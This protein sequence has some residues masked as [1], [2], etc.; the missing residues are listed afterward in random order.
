MMRRAFI[1]LGGL[2]AVTIGAAAC[3]LLV[4]TG[5]LSNPSST[6]GGGSSPPTGTSSGN[7]SVPDGGGTE[8]GTLDEGGPSVARSYAEMILTTPG[9]IGYWRFGD[10]PGSASAASAIAGGKAGK[11]NQGVTLGAPSA[12]KNDPT[13]R[14]FAFSDTSESSVVD[15]GSDVFAFEGKSPFSIELWHAPSS[16]QSFQVLIG[17]HNLDNPGAS[18]WLMSVEDPYGYAVYRED[19]VSGDSVETRLVPVAGEVHHLVATYDGTYLHLYVDGKEPSSARLC[20]RSLPSN[21]N[22]PLRVGTTTFGRIDEVALYNRALRVDEVSVHY[23]KG[24]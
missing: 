12:I 7:P 6:D 15:F 14:S 5:D 23:T 22:L 24:K 8:S 11:I 13:D 21:P 2:A 19:G 20:D 9:V 16:L 10:P 3:T 1:M 17:K 18:G 4:S